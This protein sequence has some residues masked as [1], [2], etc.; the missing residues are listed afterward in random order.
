MVDSTKEKNRERE[1]RLIRLPEV[2]KKTGLQRRTILN[3]RKKGRFPIPVPIGERAIAWLESEVND[4]IEEK[5]KK[6]D[7]SLL[8]TIKDKE[9]GHDP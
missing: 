8:I 6:R 2:I 1:Y 5:I 4:W 3:L 7:Q 9:G